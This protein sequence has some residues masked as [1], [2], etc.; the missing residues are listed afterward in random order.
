MEDVVFNDIYYSVRPETDKTLI[1][2][3]KVVLVNSGTIPIDSFRLKLAQ[4]INSISSYNPVAIGVD[5]QF[6]IHKNAFFDSILNE[7]FLRNK[8]IVLAIDGKNRRNAI[9]ESASKGAANF[10][11]KLTE[12]VRE[13]YIRMVDDKDTLPSFAY[14]LCK[15]K[16][17]E[18]ESN[19]DL[20][21]LKYSTV[22]K[23][24][25]NAMKMM[26]E[27]KAYN[28]QAI[29][30]IDI[31]NNI[32]SS[33]FR[34]I[35]KNKII[36]VGHLGCNSMDNIYDIEDKYRVPTDSSLI[37]R[38]PIMPGSVIHA[39]AVQMI[40]SNNSIVEID[41]W[42]YEIFTSIILMLYLF[43]FYTIHH[44][45]HLNKLINLI[46]LFGSTVPFIFVFGVWHMNI[47]IHY[48]VGALFLQIAFLEE[49]IEI[50]EGFINKFKRKILS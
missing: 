45:F 29:E 22:G 28:F 5:I 36:I 46:I 19:K 25:Y 2:E 33:F 11:C 43:I 20:T 27:N 17:N 9:F 10:P 13:Y 41:G 31:I 39:N 14:S 4:V 6:D 40:L 30:A 1:T 21:Y 38:A 8:K 26:E 12:S 50:S 44:R 48:K 7:T 37:N 18:I 15:I 49:F 35:I 23:G 24:F 47:G 42:R 16:N 3:K 34:E 32:D